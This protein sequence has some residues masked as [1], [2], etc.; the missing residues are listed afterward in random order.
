MR[1]WSKRERGGGK[2][3]RVSERVDSQL[4]YYTVT[5]MIMISEKE[6]K[7]KRKKDMLKI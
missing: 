4:M 2:N 6:R 1:R 5:H 3:L 7:E